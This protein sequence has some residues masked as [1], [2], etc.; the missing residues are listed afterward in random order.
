MGW[1]GSGTV[2]LLYDFTTDRDAG[3]PSSTIS[4]DKFDALL[5]DMAGSIEECLNINGE[6]TIAA[7]INWGSFR[8][9]SLGAATAAT[10]A[11][12]ARQ[13]AENAVQYG[14]T[15]GGSANAYTATNT[16]LTTP[17]AGTRLLLKA[18]FTNTGATTLNVNAAGAISVR[19]SDGAT[20]LSG[21]EIVNGDFFEVVY[22]G[23][24]YRLFE[25]ATLVRG[26]A[27]LPPANDGASLGSVSFSFADLYLASGGVINWNNGNAVLT[28]STGML[29]VTTGDLRVTTAGTNSASVVTVGGT[30]TLTNK[31]LTSPTLTSASLT[32]PSLTDA[33]LTS[34]TMTTPV[35]GTPSSG[36]LTN[37]SGLPIGGV[38]NLS[39]TPGGRLTLTSGS[40]VISEATG[41][42]TVYYT[43][44]LHNYV[45]IY[46]GTQF[47]LT[48]TGGELS[49]TTTDTTKSPAAVAASK[50]YD[51]FVWSDSGTI[52]CTRG[53]T[54]DSGAVAGSDTAR[55]TGA[56]S[57]ELERVNGIWVNKNAIT[58]GPAA[59]RGTY[60]GT[61]RSNASSTIDWKPRAEGT[62]TG[63]LASLHVWN[64][65]NRVRV[66]AISGDSGSSYTYA[67]TTI[68]AT[69]GQTANA[70]IQFVSGLA[71]DEF[72]LLRQ[73]V[74]TTAVAGDRALAGIGFNSTT[75][76]LV[77]TKSNQSGTTGVNSGQ[78]SYGHAAQLGAHYFSHLESTEASASLTFYPNDLPQ[79][80]LRWQC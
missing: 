16:F 32:S 28:H 46:D 80:M 5:A 50:N 34:P 74:F 42:T 2:T 11:I 52:R 21:G 23:T 67:S 73:Q 18:S 20:S 24:N 29:T 60:V 71:E 10:D 77:N 14:G 61:I 47:I 51:M 35:L 66:A 79:L 6:T 31:T 72:D 4:A 48:N 40:P 64:M 68:R 70:R 22:D 45:P 39:I 26:P 65:Y 56:G 54:W 69:R 9:T 30:Q 55:G 78:A 41:A 36:T 1:N 63:M 75:G 7:N 53:P 57:T 15:T 13:V 62:T 8:I 19:C 58:N 49:Q 59:R 33:S 3:P 27:I 17:A 76:V 12:R 43:P 25:D 44:H 38:N 37:C